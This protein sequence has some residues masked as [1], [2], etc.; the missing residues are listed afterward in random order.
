MRMKY[1]TCCQ[2]ID[3]FLQRIEFHVR[4]MSECSILELTAAVGEIGKFVAAQAISVG[5][6]SNQG[7][8]SMFL[9]ALISSKYQV[10]LFICF[11]L[12]RLSS[13]PRMLSDR[14]AISTAGAAH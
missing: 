8:I 10:H 6:P 11:S 9:R 7:I 5:W 14:Q 13:H 1:L 3:G 12:V 2:I 4:R